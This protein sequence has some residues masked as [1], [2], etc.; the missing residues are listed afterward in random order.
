MKS[1]AAQILRM[2]K[3][4]GASV[5]SCLALVMVVGCPT[6]GGGGGGGGGEA[7]CQA[8]SDCDDGLFCNGVES[9]T[10]GSC[11]RTTDAPCGEGEECDDDADACVSLPQGFQDADAT[12]G[13]SLYD[14]WWAVAGVDAPTEDHPRWA[15]QTTN[16]RS[17][18]DTWRCK[19][20]HGWDYKGEQGAYGSGSHMTGFPGVFGTNSSAQ[21]VF[22]KVKDE[23]GFGTAG[24]SDEDIWDLAKFVL[25]GAL[26]GRA[27]V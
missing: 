19:E 21:G 14:K 6:T 18:A 17:G 25:D 27:H 24:L 26:I 2:S 4:A 23:H 11:I 3:F 9:C 8:D 12:R 16:T 15:S 13:G 1:I 5:L 10:G 20:C 7:E 22:D